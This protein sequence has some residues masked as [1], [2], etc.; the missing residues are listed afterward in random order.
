MRADE[1]V[2]PG[3]ALPEVRWTGVLAEEVAPAKIVGKYQATVE[4]GKEKASRR[5]G[6]SDCMDRSFHLDEISLSCSDIPAGETGQKNR[7]GK[8]RPE[9]S[10]RC[11]RGDSECDRCKRHE[12]GGVSRSAVGIEASEPTR[13][14]EQKGKREEER[15]RTFS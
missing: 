8:G 14:A 9:P 11:R 15:R 7:E 6:R 2:T 3:A 12:I 1:P 10:R 4:V 13:R 5:Y